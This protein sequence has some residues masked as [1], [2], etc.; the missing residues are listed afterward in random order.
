[1]TLMTP[2]EEEKRQFIMVIV[3]HKRGGLSLS[4]CGYQGEAQRRWWSSGEDKSDE[5]NVECSFGQLKIYLE[6]F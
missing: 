3:S 6:I 2:L 4:V 1:M 5:G